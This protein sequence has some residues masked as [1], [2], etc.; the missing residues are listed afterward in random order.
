M[1]AARFSAN[2]EFES[3]TEQL[4]DLMQ[5]CVDEVARL[6]GK[7]AQPVPVAKRSPSKPKTSPPLSPAPVDLLIPAVAATPTRSSPLPPPPPPPVMIPVPVVVP[8]PVVDPLK[9]PPPPTTPILVPDDTSSAPPAAAPVSAVPYTVLVRTNADSGGSF[10]GQ[11]FITL[12][13]AN[14]ASTEVRIERGLNWDP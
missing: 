9:A 5:L 6:Q 14:G 4:T 1:D 10:D 7:Q 11:V 12:L 8:A 2:P 13:G 3:T